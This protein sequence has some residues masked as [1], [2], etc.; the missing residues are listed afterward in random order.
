MLTAGFILL[1]NAKLSKNDAKSTKFST[2]AK[3]SVDKKFKKQ[4][5]MRLSFG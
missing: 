4:E 5:K 3:V 1:K 2:Y